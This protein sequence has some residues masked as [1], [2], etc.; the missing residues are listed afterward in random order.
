MKSLK[1]LFGKK[2]RGYV[3]PE[4]LDYLFLC[5]EFVQRNM[6][7]VM[8]RARGEKVDDFLEDLSQDEIDRYV[9][10]GKKMKKKMDM[11]LGR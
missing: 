5:P 4:D 11:D 2:E 1:S 3:S 7:V 9:A 10:E 8:A 6:A